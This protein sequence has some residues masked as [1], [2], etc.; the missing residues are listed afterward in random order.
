MKLVVK[1]VEMWNAV[2]APT[3]VLV[4][5]IV[6]DGCWHGF[7]KMLASLV[8]AGAHIYESLNHR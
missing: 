4:A 3:K 6:I 1:V 2:P 8:V 7:E 5:V